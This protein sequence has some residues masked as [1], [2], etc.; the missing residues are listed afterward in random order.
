[1]KKPSSNFVRQNQY[2]KLIGGNCV[3]V[4]GWT[5]KKTSMQ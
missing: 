1:M 3:S 4:R 2:S 5:K